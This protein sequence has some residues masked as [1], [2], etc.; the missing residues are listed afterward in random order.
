MICKKCFYNLYYNESGACPECGQSFDPLDPSTYRDRAPDTGF[1]RYRFW[2]WRIVK[3]AILP[4][5][6]FFP[7]PGFPRPWDLSPIS[8]CYTFI[9]SF[10]LFT[11]LIDFS[12]ALMRQIFNEAKLLR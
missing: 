4:L 7:I 3:T 2:I 5:V 6:L 10:I 11:V 1:R 8:I 9:I 12:I